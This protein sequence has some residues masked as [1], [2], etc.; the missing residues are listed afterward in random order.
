MSIV[1][2][3]ASWASEISLLRPYLMRVALSR[4]N[5]REAAE[6]VVQEALAAAC[7][8]DAKFTGRSTPA[9]LGDRHPAAQGHGRLP[10]RGDAKQGAG[11]WR[12]AEDDDRRLSTRTAAGA[13]R[14]MHGR[15]PSAR[16]NAAASAPSSTRSSSD[17][18]GC[19][20]APS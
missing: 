13:R 5:D 2:A 1:I 11:T 4:L 16:S 19:R 9:H 8:N 3:A 6:D 10:R 14:R 18:P 20:R 12:P 17:C 7:A 15:I